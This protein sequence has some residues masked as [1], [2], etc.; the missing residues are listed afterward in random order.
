MPSLP[1]CVH[2]TTLLLLACA[3]ACG[4]DPA[5]A[6]AQGNGSTTSSD[7]GTD[8]ESDD[9]TGT[10]SG[11]PPLPLCRTFD[12]LTSLRWQHMV[13]RDVFPGMSSMLALD[14]GGVAVGGRGNVLRL[15]ADGN[16]L[17][18]H[19]PDVGAAGLGPP[20]SDGDFSIVA[21]LDWELVL[22][23]FRDGSVSSET[24]TAFPDGRLWG[25]AFHGRGGSTIVTVL[26]PSVGSPRVVQLRDETLSVEHS[27]TMDSGEDIGDAA[28]GE[29][30]TVFIA[31]PRA[32]AVAV[33][34]IR[35]GEPVWSMERPAEP[36]EVFQYSATVTAGSVVAL[37]APGASAPLLGI[38]PG[39]GS[40]LWE[41]TL[42]AS[43]LDRAPCGTI[44][45]IALSDGDHVLFALE[46][47]GPTALTSIERPNTDPPVSVH[48]VHVGPDGTVFVAWTH[49]NSDNPSRFVVITAY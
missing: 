27:Y 29:D 18:V 22:T 28:A 36:T 21:E 45:A 19:T 2:A 39:N 13:D 48:S 34:A 32:D 5:G 23:E 37:S 20:L 4:E 33:T 14:D 11:E 24:V 25:P 47:A 41:S 38:A 3:T 30:G 43:A 49:G 35:D 7:D 26:R 12:D 44:L 6:Q 15:D 10:E 16:Q 31:S 42:S 9:E 46:P 17:A 8:A 1:L 40:V